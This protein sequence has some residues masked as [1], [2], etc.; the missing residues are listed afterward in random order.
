MEGEMITNYVRQQFDK[1]VT[2]AGPDD[3]WLWMG[4]RNG[5]GQ[6]RAYGRIRIGKKAVRVHRL[7]TEVYIGV[8]SPPGGVWRHLCNNPPCVNPAHLAWGTQKDNMQDCAKSG[9]K[10]A[11]AARGERSANAKL[12]WQGVDDIRLW[13][14]K[15]L[16]NISNLSYVFNVSRA[17]I[18]DVVRRRSWVK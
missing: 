15:G 13:Y 8:P 9:R 10:R 11:T 7:A 2:K 17:V 5:G 18:R 3:C 14:D 4:S 1:Y 12:T 16:A 6:S